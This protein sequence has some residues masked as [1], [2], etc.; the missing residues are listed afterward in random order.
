MNEL[1]IAKALPEPAPQRFNAGGVSTKLFFRA[2]IDGVPFRRS[3]RW[4]SEFH[5]HAYGQ[6]ISRCAVS[7]RMRKGWDV[8][9]ACLAKKGESQQEY[10]ERAK[11]V[12]FNIDMK[13][14]AMN[15]FIYGCRRAAS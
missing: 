9:A 5:L 2:K 12:V 10:F 7:E 4:W 14:S 11:K 6:P 8:Q 1:E 3:A 15:T 13:E